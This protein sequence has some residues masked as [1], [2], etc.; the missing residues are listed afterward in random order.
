MGF[1]TFGFGVEMILNPEEDIYWGSEK[2]WLGVN[3]YSGNRELENPLELSHM[4]LTYVNP[5]GPDANPDP[6]LAA[7]DIR[8]TF[9]KE[10]L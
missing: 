6:L 4:G 9:L 2:E 7:H 3:R 8:E 10:W 1:K 5:Q